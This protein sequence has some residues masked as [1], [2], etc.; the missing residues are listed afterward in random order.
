[1]LGQTGTHIFRH[2][3]HGL[4][5]G[6]AAMINPLPDLLGAHIRLPIRHPDG[7]Q[8]HPQV[9][10]REAQNILTGIGIGSTGGNHRHHWPQLAMGAP[11]WSPSE[12][13]CVIFINS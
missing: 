5:I 11:I 4:E 13:I 12:C 2:I 7:Q 3:A 6:D 1:M 8:G 10:A 9:F